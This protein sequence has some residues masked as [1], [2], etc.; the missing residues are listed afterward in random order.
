[1]LPEAEIFGVPPVTIKPPP[2]VIVPLVLMVPGEN[3][4]VML[5]LFALIFPVVEILLA[6]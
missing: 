5:R 3:V 1:M 4:P 2:V 6:R